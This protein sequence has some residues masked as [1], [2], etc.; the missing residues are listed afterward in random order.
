MVSRSVYEQARGLRS[1]FWPCE[2]FEFSNHLFDQGFALVIIQ[3][4]FVQYRI[5]ALAVTTQ[6][7]M[8]T[9]DKVGYVTQYLKLRRAGHVGIS[10]TEFMTKRQHNPW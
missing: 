3:E 8:Q 6:K 2:D 4:V 7:Q 1:Q 10:L 9:F 5:H